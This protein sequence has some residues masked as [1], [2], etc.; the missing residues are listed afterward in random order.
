MVDDLLARNSPISGVAA[1]DPSS[2]LAPSLQVLRRKPLSWRRGDKLDQSVWPGVDRHLVDWA[3][4]QLAWTLHGR[5]LL[6][7][8]RFELL[9][10]DVDTLESQW[11]SPAVGEKMMRGLD[12]GFIPMRPL[13]RHQRVFARQ[14]YQP[15]PAMVCLRF[16]TGEQVWSSQGEDRVFVSDPFFVADQ[17]ACLTLN[18]EPS[19]DADLKL[20]FLDE[21][22]GRVL[23][24]VDLLRLR[25]TWW[26]RRCCEVLVS[27]D[28][29]V[30]LLGGLTVAFDATGQVLWI[31]KTEPLPPEADALWVR[32]QYQ[33]AFLTDAGL[34]VAQPGVRAIECLKPES[35]LLC[36][37]KV[38]PD[39]EAMLGV[40]G[41]SLIVRMSHELASLDL[42]S[43][44][45]RWRRSLDNA[46]LASLVTSRNGLMVSRA[47]GMD[48]EGERIC[49]QLIW[50]DAETGELQ[51][52]LTL[53]SLAGVR[54]RLGPLFSVGAQLF[55]F[56]GEGQW[57][58]SRELIELGSPRRE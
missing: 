26:S 4:R 43:G 45:V 20:T 47:V 17:M 36:W 34:I 28:S 2:P 51:R 7:N 50:L 55:V 18:P 31:R 30:A 42:E 35:G 5:T 44:R 3:G 21:A 12:W 19:L 13:V 53:E 10:I 22:T 41:N 40:V 38:L 14:L 27:N 11:A 54:P 6:I 9:A 52:E 29:V 49:A 46:L 56:W 16:D 8:N 25:D 15:Q 48:A 32:Q 33:P 24:S 39:V 1:E 57:S 37:K 58:P 23:R